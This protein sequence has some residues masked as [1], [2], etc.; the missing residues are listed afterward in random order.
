MFCEIL[1][2]IINKWNDWQNPLRSFKSF[3]WDATMTYLKIRS[4]NIVAPTHSRYSFY[5]W[6]NLMFPFNSLFSYLVHSLRPMWQ[7]SISNTT[8]FRQA[9]I[10]PIQISLRWLPHK[11]N[12]TLF[13]DLTTE[14][15]SLPDLSNT[16]EALP[17]FKPSNPPSLSP[18][19]LINQ[20]TFHGGQKK[21]T[22][23]RYRVKLG[24]REEPRDPNNSWHV[25]CL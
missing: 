12:W 19:E 5:S 2:L 15:S 4:I 25:S 23:V 20:D 11:A 7:W 14:T 13:T 8:H 18:L 3:S 22:W 1:L 21:F 6:L 16:L 17:S 10:T 24:F 9:Y